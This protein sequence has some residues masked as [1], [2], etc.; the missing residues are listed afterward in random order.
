MLKADQSKELSLK[1][2]SIQGDRALITAINLAE[3]AIKAAAADGHLE[4][5]ITIT[6]APGLSK[7]LGEAG[8]QVQEVLQEGILAPNLYMPPTIRV[9]IRWGG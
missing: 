9:F 8:Y 6:R 2:R 7:V 4:T 3:K 1:N 5:S